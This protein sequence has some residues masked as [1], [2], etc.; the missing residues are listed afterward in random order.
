MSAS[1]SPFF[2]RASAG[3]RFLE[4]P[5]LQKR[6]SP[7]FIRASAG[8]GAG[9]RTSGST[10]SQSLLHQGIGRTGLLGGEWRQYRVSVPSSSGH[11]PDE[12]TSPPR[13]NRLCLSPFF[14]R[15]SAGHCSAISRG[16]PRGLSPFF[17]RASGGPLLR[18]PGPTALESQSLLH[19][20]IGRTTTGSRTSDETLVSVPSSSG[21]RPDMIV[22]VCAS[23]IVGL[24]PFFIR[25]SGGLADLRQGPSAE[26]SVPS[27]SGHRADR[28][29]RENRLVSLVSVPSSSGHRP[30][31]IADA[32]K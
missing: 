15:A 32:N 30:D 29:G 10:M 6:L 17:I 14:I 7:F 23:A 24:S 21:H 20:G 31:S 2:I 26:V 1:L 27:S 25:A 5:P 28:T 9:S 12:G 11:R 3:R 4:Q 22:G 19:Q 18:Y 13:S 16:K 8:R